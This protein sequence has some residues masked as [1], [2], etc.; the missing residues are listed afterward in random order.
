MLPNRKYRDKDAEHFCGLGIEH[1]KLQNNVGVIFRTA[2]ILSGVDFLFTIG[3]KYHRPHDDTVSSYKSTPIWN[4]TSFDDLLERKPLGCD[5]VGVE[6][7]KR[8][9]PLPD[10][11]WAS[12]TIILLGAEGEGLSPRARESCREL[13]YI[14]SSMK[15]SLNVSSVAAIVLYDR[16]L[17]MRK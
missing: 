12:R 9:K 5:I 7:D 4:F 17:K 15:V 11:K 16:Y 6:L 3:E 13:I 14:P 8:A 10:Y 1:P 2:A